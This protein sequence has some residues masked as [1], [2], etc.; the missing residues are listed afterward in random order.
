MTPPL[1]GIKIIE[2]ESL[3]PAPFCGMLLGDLG[4]EI[5]LIKRPIST[6]PFQG[7][8]VPLIDQGKTAVKLDLKSRDDSAQLK[9]LVQDADGLIEGM[10]PGVMERLGL[11]PGDLA[12][13]NP[14]LV[15]GRV[16]GWGQDGPLSRAAGHDINYSALS[17][18]LWFSGQP[19]QPPLAPPTLLADIGGGALYLSV[20]ILSALLQAK[21]TGR[22]AVIDAAMIDGSAHMLN[23]LL[24][25]IPAG[26]IREARGTSPLDG[27]HWYNTYA[28]HDKKYITVGSLEPKFY[29]LLLEKL[30]LQA[31]P[32]F[33]DQF[34]SAKWPELK[35]RFEALFAM[36]TQAEWCDLLEGTD[37][38]FAPVLTPS[39]AAEHP[40]M[41]VRG[42]YERRDGRL[43]AAPAPRFKN[44]TD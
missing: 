21:S 28:C 18:A 23:L 6:S 29:A 31:E 39:E 42:I 7:D 44:L 2:I 1:E 13:I 40:H 33:S 30:D 17:G 41:K 5:T 4:A 9:T 12:P 37:V 22:G 32:E 35:T 43:R 20:G 16:T 15:Y 3:G 27:A 11:G 8:N 14:A 38:C 10:R 26:V 25:A 36:K 34:D 24:T 19:E